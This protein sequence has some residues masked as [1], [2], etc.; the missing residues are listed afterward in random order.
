[1]L[2][3]RKEGDQPANPELCAEEIFDKID[4]ALTLCEELLVGDKLTAEEKDALD[5]VLIYLDAL[6]QRIAGED[7]E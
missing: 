3:S 5:I 7:D 6:E 2:K 4:A 1:M